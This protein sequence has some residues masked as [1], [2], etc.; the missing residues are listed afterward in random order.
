M[1]F[2]IDLVLFS[3]FWFKKQSIMNIYQ[4]QNSFYKTL[5]EAINLLVA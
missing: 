3:K 4:V 5:Q 1:M 2:L